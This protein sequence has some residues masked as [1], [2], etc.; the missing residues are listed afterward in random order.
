MKTTKE[1]GAE[2]ERIA[3]K[4]YQ[5]LGHSVLARNYRIPSGEIDLVLINDRIFELVF[6]EVKSRKVFPEGEAWEPYWKEKKRKLRTAMR[7]FLNRYPEYGPAE[8]RLEIV[9][10]TQGR[11]SQCF[12][13]GFF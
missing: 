12:D 8:M 10:V 1:K 2:A 5:S 9:Y 11:V 3:E 6:V 13:G 7:S 4:F